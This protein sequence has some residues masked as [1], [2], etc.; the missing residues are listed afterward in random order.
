M[1]RRLIG[2]ALVLLV[3]VGAV[4]FPAVRQRQQ[5]VRA[6]CAAAFEKDKTALEGYHWAWFPPGWVCEFGADTRRGHDR[7]Y[8]RRL[9]LSA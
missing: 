7:G 1:T 9:P 2:A 5:D 4:A 3:L 8:E 6:E